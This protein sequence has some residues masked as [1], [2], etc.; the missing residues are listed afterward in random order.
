MAARS[1]GVAAGMLGAC[2][3]MVMVISAKKF[4]GNVMDRMPHGQLDSIDFDQ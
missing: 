4:R 2:F 3:F 1:V